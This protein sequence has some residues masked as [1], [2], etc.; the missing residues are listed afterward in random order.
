VQAINAVRSGV[1]ALVELHCYHTACA[2]L[3]R[4][5]A[6]FTIVCM[7]HAACKYALVRHRLQDACNV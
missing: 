4:N 7:L 1:D 2:T 3:D 5:A 6:C